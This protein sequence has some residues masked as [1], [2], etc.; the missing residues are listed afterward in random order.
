MFDHIQNRIYTYIYVY[1]FDIWDLC[2]MLLRFFPQEHDIAKEGRCFPLIL[3]SHV[4]CHMLYLHSFP[5]RG[6]RSKLWR[7]SCWR[8]CKLS[9]RWSLLKP[10][11]SNRAS[12]FHTQDI[13]CK[14]SSPTRIMYFL[15]CYMYQA[16]GL[17]TAVLL[18]DNSS[19][20]STCGSILPRDRPRKF[21]VPS[22]PV[23]SMQLVTPFC[24]VGL[25]PWGC[26]SLF[27]FMLVMLRHERLKKQIRSTKQWW[28]RLAPVS[29]W[30]VQMKAG[31]N[32]MVRMNEWMNEWRNEGMKW[33]ERTNERTN[34]QRKE[35]TSKG[36]NEWV[37]EWVRLM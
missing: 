33:C 17:C 14:K 18:Y 11:L 23:T 24:F 9:N 5:P 19:G 20:G 29:L 1:I 7:K 31:R 4:I 16:H 22:W 3:G 35:W 30:V 8:R 2:I 37:T 34:E 36:T 32:E 6:R 21:P 15:R 27:M 25:R 12:C 13:V 28:T 10:A 26:R